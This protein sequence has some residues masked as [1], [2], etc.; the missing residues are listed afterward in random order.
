MGN[1][2]LDLGYSFLCVSVS[3]DAVIITDVILLS[4]E[5][6]EGWSVGDRLYLLL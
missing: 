1:D 6:H 4:L 5:I 2:G 3:F